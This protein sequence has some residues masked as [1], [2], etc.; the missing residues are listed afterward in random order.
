MIGLT[1]NQLNILTVL[2]KSRTKLFC[3]KDGNEGQDCEILVDYQMLERTR[4]KT[5]VNGGESPLYLLTSTGDNVIEEFYTSGL[6]TMETLKE[7]TLCK[8]E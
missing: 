5:I 4:T 7:N 2:F 6:N 8:P 3:P 1:K